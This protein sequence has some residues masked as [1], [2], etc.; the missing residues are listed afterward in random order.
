M[1]PVSSTSGQTSPPVEAQGLTRR[2]GSTVAVDGIDLL[3]EP[4]EIFGFLGPNGAGKTTCVR[5]LV[6]L[7]RPTGGWARVAG[8]DVVRE[9]TRVRRAIGVALQQAAVDPIMTGRELL[10]LQGTLH[11]LGK[12]QT[13]ERGA[14]LFEHLGLVSAAD[15]QVSTYS[16]GMRRRLDLALALLHQP[17]VL[18]LDEPTAG[19]DPTSRL[20]LWE[21][22]RRLNVERGTS[23]FLTTQYLEEADQLARRVAIIDGG[24]IVREGTPE[25]LKAEVGSPTLTVDVADRSREAAEGVLARYGERV[26]QTDGKVA[27]RLPGGP[28]AVPGIVRALDAAQIVLE[29]MAL[30]APTLDDVFAAATGRRLERSDD[31]EPAQPRA[32]PAGISTGSTPVTPADEGT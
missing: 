5:M 29:G 2:F 20:S 24:R 12:A 3:V 11:G 17:D 28:A 15:Q 6:T 21:E 26:P 7:L 16:G 9:A 13:T 30:A 31:D 25:H 22:V 10:R 14:E 18:F 23:V 1:A 32:R 4:G 19:L 27:V 8:Y